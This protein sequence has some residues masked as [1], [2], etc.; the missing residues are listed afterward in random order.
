M[1]ELIRLRSQINEVIERYE[2]LHNMAAQQAAPI[3]GG[4]GLVNT[5]RGN[6]HKLDAWYRGQLGYLEHQAIK[7]AV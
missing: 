3:Q 2:R 5:V 1:E 7:E 4:L 6:L